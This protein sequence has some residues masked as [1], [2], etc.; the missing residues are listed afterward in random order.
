MKR[1]FSKKGCVVSITDVDGR[2]FLNE[3]KKDKIVSS[4]HITN[5][6]AEK[7]IKNF[8]LKKEK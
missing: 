4:Q 2:M 3:I 1:Y 5:E 7:V 6:E 8:K